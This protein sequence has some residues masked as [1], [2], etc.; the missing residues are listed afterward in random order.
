MKRNPSPLPRD[1]A[2]PPAD[3]DLADP[4]GRI[5]ALLRGRSGNDFASYKAS[6]VRRRI[7]RR[8]RI[9][10]LAGLDAY[11]R[12]LQ[13]NPHE[14]DLLFKDLLI[15]V[16]SFFRDPEA[17]AS[18]SELAL[19][20]LL[21]GRAGAHPVR[22]W[23]PGCSTGQDA[24][25]LAIVLTEC[26]ESLQLH[27]EVQIYAT[28]LDSQAVHIARSGTYPE[29]I[30]GEVSAARLGR[31]FTAVPEGY[32]ISDAIR[33]MVV[34]APHNVLCDP[35][36]TRL[37]ILCCRNLLIYL[38]AAMQARLLQ[39]LHYALKPSGVL[40]IGAA[41]SLGP[42][43]GAFEPLDTQWR[44]YRKKDGPLRAPGLVGP[45]SA[46]PPASEREDARPPP[47]PP[48]LGELATQVLL[49]AY[50]PPSA[51]ISEQG[52]IC[53]LHGRIGAYL[54]PPPGPPT[55]NL[56][57]LVRGALQVALR[58][59]LQRAA[60]RDEP[61]AQR[62]VP[63]GEAGQGALLDVIVRRLREPEALAGLFLVTLAPAGPPGSGRRRR[64]DP[65]LGLPQAIAAA[66]SAHDDLRLANEELQARSEQL[67]SV[68]AELAAAHDAVRAL[69][70]ELHTVSAELRSKLGE[71][72]QL[73][74]DMTEL[75]E[76]TNTATVFLTSDLRI[77]RFTGLA[78]QLIHFL[79]TDVGRPLGDLATRLRGVPLAERAA[80]V[81]R[82]QRAFETEVQ[83]EEQQW[84]LLRIVP[85]KA[86][87]KAAQTATEQPGDGVLLTFVDITRYKAPRASTRRRSREAAGRIRRGARR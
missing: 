32:R 3:E 82:T 4:L 51:V 7:E 84:Y 42:L 10:Q 83:S 31:H 75:L 28:D 26:L 34:F 20:P 65:S 25:A 24:Y 73:Q 50:A 18:F 5:L 44:L 54:E 58:Q 86:T 38:S 71:L 35:P 62:G 55:H 67:H 33:Q 13:Q 81:L 37:D 66:Q 11:Y 70:E 30:A 21:R 47:R 74:A 48:G 61:A 53:H 2:R 69:H 49:E 23:V 12:F 79:P 56:L 9:H 22:A 27:L 78:R 8:V 80:E 76:S 29:S 87:Q 72:S 63:T 39:Q 6:T 45:W 36:F 16:T 64:G 40:L 19:L 1:L 43:A 77:K 15:G 17:F 57:K 14:V 46:P 60:Q 85:Q 59:A 52:E 41:E 68:H